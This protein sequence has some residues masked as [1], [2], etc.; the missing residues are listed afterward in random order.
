[1]NF[2]ELN[3]EES[4]PVKEF[5]SPVNGNYIIGANPFNQPESENT[6]S[7]FS[8]YDK[9]NAREILKV[10]TKRSFVWYIDL[11]LKNEIKSDY[12]ISN[13]FITKD[14]RAKRYSEIRSECSNGFKTNIT[15]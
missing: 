7:V 12:V 6:T 1:M 4:T 8:V 5:V 11:V 14:G 15:A 9:R 3:I 2:K 13:K 10:E